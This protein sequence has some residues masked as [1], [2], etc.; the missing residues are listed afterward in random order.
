MAELDR[1]FKIYKGFYCQFWAVLSF[2]I[3][4]I[5]L[6]L[7]YTANAFSPFIAMVAAGIIGISLLIIVA[8]H[9]KL[10]KQTRTRFEKVLKRYDT[11]FWLLASLVLISP[12]IVPIT[13]GF[14][15]IYYPIYTLLIVYIYIMPFLLIYTL[16]ILQLPL[17]DS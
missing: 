1:K 14:G 9:Y 11:L 5:S 8:Y 10:E 12:A 17:T 4:I 13:A 2:C 7:I 15:H 6:T 3:P 16:K